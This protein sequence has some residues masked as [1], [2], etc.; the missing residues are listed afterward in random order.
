M[1]TPNDRRL[2]TDADLHDAADEAERAER[3][4]P[5][6]S[7]PTTVT[8]NGE[9]WTK[10][11]HVN[12]WLDGAPRFAE[13]VEPTWYWRTSSGIESGPRESEMLNHIAELERERDE[14]LIADLTRQLA[15][16]QATIAT[17]AGAVTLMRDE[18]A[19]FLALAM[20]AKALRDDPQPYFMESIEAVE[21]FNEL[22][23]HAPVEDA[24]PA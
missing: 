9:T 5:P 17:Y 16:A 24:R 10:H 21:I 15:D 6:A 2:Y 1:T 13:G 14:A 4:N 8:V 19:P 3:D 18:L 20:R 11:Q 12:Y 22:A 23:A 7:A